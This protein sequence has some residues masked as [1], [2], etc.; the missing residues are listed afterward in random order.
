MYRKS[1]MYSIFD[2]PYPSKGEEKCSNV[3]DAKNLKSPLRGDPEGSNK[4]TEE[5]FISYFL[6]YFIFIIYTVSKQ[7]ILLTTS[8]IRK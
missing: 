4:E 2:L 7:Q 1:I 3:K 5:P 8:I 6:L